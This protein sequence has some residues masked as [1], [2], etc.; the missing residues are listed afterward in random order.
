MDNDWQ[1]I[2]AYGYF[3]IPL[4]CNV[5]REAI[6]LKCKT[7]NCML[8]VKPRIQSDIVTGHNTNTYTYICSKL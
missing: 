2:A 4:I 6:K 5:G 1:T 7:N 8:L 3:H